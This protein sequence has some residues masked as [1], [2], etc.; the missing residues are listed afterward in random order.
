MLDCLF[1]FIVQ[2]IIEIERRG[3]KSELRG[4][5]FCLT[6]KHS[7]FGGV[8]VRPAHFDGELGGVFPLLYGVVQHTGTP[9][10]TLVPFHVLGEV[11]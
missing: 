1:A 6:F 2:L 8:L 11:L 9:A 5:R 7:P 10:V 4:E 3:K